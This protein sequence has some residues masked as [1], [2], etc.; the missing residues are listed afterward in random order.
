MARK[1]VKFEKVSEEEK[2]EDEERVVVAR[3]LKR[4][5][6]KNEEV[7]ISIRMGKKVDYMNRPRFGKGL[8]ITEKIDINKFLIWLLESIKK[9]Y[10]KAFKKE[11]KI[12]TEIELYKEQIDRL[13]TELADAKK[14]LEELEQ[15]KEEK[16]RLYELAEKILGEFE[17]Y[18]ENFDEFVKIVNKS[19]NEKIGLEEKIKKFLKENPWI[20]GLECH[21]EAKNRRIDSRFQIDLHVITKYNQDRIFELKSPNLRPFK[22]KRL[23]I[24]QELAE[25][26]SELIRY[27]METDVYSKIESSSL[28]GIHKSTG[29]I[30]MGYNLSREEQ[31]LLDTLNFFLFPYVQIITYND[32]IQNAK[33]ELGIIQDIKSQI[34][35]Q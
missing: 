1:R 17:K 30:I 11:V 25:G 22:G 34:I 15:R 13:T 32:L 29:V 28:Y 27:M 9:L 21:V 5:A 6:P 7:G 3:V 26:L 12:E 35:N 18:K 10:R 4:T 19:F 20:L 2:W 33:R 16:K 31:Q 23:L 24:S 14:K 8:W